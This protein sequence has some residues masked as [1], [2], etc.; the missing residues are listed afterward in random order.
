MEV[1]RQIH[2]PAPLSPGKNP[3]NVS[4]KVGGHQSRSGRFE[5]QET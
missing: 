2:T 3:G 5:E 1:S 4:R